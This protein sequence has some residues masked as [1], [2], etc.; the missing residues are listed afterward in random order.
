[1]ELCDFRNKERSPNAE[2]GRR[3]AHH[4]RRHALFEWSVRSQWAA[5]MESLLFIE[6]DDGI[7]LALSLALEDEG[8]SVREA[9]NGT[10]GLA[11]FDAACARPRVARPASARHV[12]VRRVPADPGQ[13][14]RADHHH[15]GADRHPRHGRR[16]RSRRRR[17]RHQAG[18]A[19]GTRRPDP[20]APAAGAPARCGAA[21]I[22]Q[23][24]R[25]HRV[26]AR[27]R[28][29]LQG[30]QGDSTSPRPSSGCCASSPI[31]PV[32]C[33]RGISCSNACGGTST[34]A[35][36][37]SSMRTSVGCA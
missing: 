36:R 27:A 29:R 1:M 33:C 37:V 32:R 4:V 34:S 13:E 21:G 18:R 17:L 25:R 15:H 5:A 31:T 26:A 16:P 10:D 28:P 9:A 24:V 11:A 35:I 8:Y 20:G 6:D 2:S 12:R 22:G 19:E 3:I 7:R 14:H 30:R 23:L